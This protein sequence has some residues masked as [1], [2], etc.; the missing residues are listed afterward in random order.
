MTT[1]ETAAPPQLEQDLCTGCAACCD[2]T[3]FGYVEVSRDEE[4]ALGGL[5]TMESRKDDA[6]FY[7]P[8]PHSVGQRCQIYSR[9][10]ETCR[11]FHCHTLKALRG[12]EIESGEAVRRVDQMLKQR[13]QLQADLLKDETLNQAR[14]R[15]QMIASSQERTPTEMTFLLKLTAFDLLLDRYFRDPRKSMFGN[16]GPPSQPTNASPPHLD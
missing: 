4:V 13:E 3:I 11:K 12:G 9:R 8:C 1:R 2:G 6:I 7:Q 14:N 16:E 15:R 10:P 5:F